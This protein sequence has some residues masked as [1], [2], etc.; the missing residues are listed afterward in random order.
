M[1]FFNFILLYNFLLLCP[2]LFKVTEAIKL[3]SIHEQN[4]ALNRMLIVACSN[5]KIL[6]TNMNNLKEIKP[7]LFPFSGDIN[8]DQPCVYSPNDAYLFKISFG[9]IH[10]VLLFRQF[11]VQHQI[12]YSPKAILQPL[13]LYCP[14]GS[15]LKQHSH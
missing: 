6:K 14:L 12:M 2:P 7:C 5:F 3:I 4:C 10:F 15:R 8:T 1:F 11:Q 13:L 9:R